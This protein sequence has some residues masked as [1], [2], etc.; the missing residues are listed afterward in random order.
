MQSRAFDQLVERRACFE[1]P[2]TEH[3]GAE[4]RHRRTVQ[5]H[6]GIDPFADSGVPFEQ[7][8]INQIHAAGPGD[9]PVN[10]DNLAVQAHVVAGEQASQQSRRQRC[11]HL[12][13]G[14]AETLRLLA[15]PP[16]A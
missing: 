2:I 12:D 6:H 3:D 13:A 15:P 8:G 10:D 16:R 1:H 4:G 11:P 5:A 7:P 14:I 9:T